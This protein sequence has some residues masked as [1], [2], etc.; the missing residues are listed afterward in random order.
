MPTLG[1]WFDIW[2]AVQRIEP[3]TKQGYESAIRFWRLAE[4]DRDHRLLGTVELSELKVSYILTAIARRPNLSGKTINNYV[5][6]MRKALDLAVSDTLLEL[7][8]AAHV[9][10]AKHQKALP[11]PFSR[12]ESERVIDEVA[13]IYPGQI[14][15]LIEFWFWTGLR[16]SEVFGLQWSNAD[17]QSGTIL[18]TEALVRGEHKDRTKTAIARTVRLNSRALAALTRQ[19]LFTHVT[20]AAIF[21]DP[22]YGTRWEDERAFRRSF[23]TPILKRLGIRYRR[24]YNMRHSYA[25]AMLMAGMTPAFCA[26]QLGHS[27]D[28]FLTT[29]ARWLDGRQDA[30]EMARLEASFNDAGDHPV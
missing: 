1:T 29:Y 28:M 15:N 11:D 23:W 27:V 9:P 25:T 26:R 8:P 3:S 22:R 24:P 18:V 2:L 17:L 20:G 7:N 16:T 14:H 21:H 19:Q 10:R 30:I 4:C 13:R 6:V 5:S 12:D